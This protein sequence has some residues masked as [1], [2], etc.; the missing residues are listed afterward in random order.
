MH[1]LTPLQANASKPTFPPLMV[2]SGSEAVLQRADAN[3]FEQLS[4]EHP[5]GSASSPAAAV[6]TAK[7]PLPSG[8]IYFSR[9]SLHFGAGSVPQGMIGTVDVEFFGDPSINLSE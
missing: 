3:T 2:V 9:K 6:L 7:A 5:L 1:A 4:P 8:R